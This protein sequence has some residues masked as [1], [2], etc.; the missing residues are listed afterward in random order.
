M[1]TFA[2]DV[3]LERQ[4]SLTAVMFAIALGDMVVSI[5]LAGLIMALSVRVAG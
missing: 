2:S 3:W 1:N 4:I 5:R